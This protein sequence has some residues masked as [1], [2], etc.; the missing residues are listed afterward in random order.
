MIHKYFIFIILKYAFQL[1]NISLKLAP[2]LY[3]F[4][5]VRIMHLNSIFATRYKI[6]LITLII[7]YHYN[8]ANY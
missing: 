4:T 6:V 7:N 3:K 5:Y 8:T 1:V 2:Q